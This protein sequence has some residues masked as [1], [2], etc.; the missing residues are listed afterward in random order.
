MF[1][2]I[3]PPMLVHGMILTQLVY[4]APMSGTATN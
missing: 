2:M 3:Y 4:I 1:T